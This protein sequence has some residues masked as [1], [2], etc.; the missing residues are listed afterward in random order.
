MYRF[1]QKWIPLNRCMWPSGSV[2]LYVQ[3]PYPLPVLSYYFV[4]FGTFVGITEKDSW[5][6]SLIPRTSVCDNLGMSLNDHLSFLLT[7]LLNGVF[8]N[9]N[10][11][12][13]A[14]L[15]RAAHSPIRCS[16]EGLSFSDGGC[17][18]GCN[19]KV[20]CNEDRQ[21][22]SD[23]VI[24]IRPKATE[25]LR[26]R[27]KTLKSNLPNFTS[28]LSVRSMLAPCKEIP[29]TFILLGENSFKQSRHK[30]WLSWP[31]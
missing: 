29:E 25:E 5:L 30:I 18:F 3:R 13:M 20:S 15:M 22:F 16:N 4:S 26:S 2:R 8:T 10:W 31:K 24:H 28:P 1:I 27:I 7:A 12:K 6:L 9:S 17:Y 23:D 11:M 14:H 21:G 19:S